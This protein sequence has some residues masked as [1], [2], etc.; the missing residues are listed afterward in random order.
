MI[1][2][3][4]PRARK[5]DPDQPKAE[6][7]EHRLDDRGN[8]RRSALLDDQARLGARRSRFDRLRHPLAFGDRQLS[9]Y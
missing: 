4:Q 9:V 7:V 8:A 3:V 1:W 6:A 2:T 5:C